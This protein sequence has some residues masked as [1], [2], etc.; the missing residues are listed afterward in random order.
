MKY[1]ARLLGQV[2]QWLGR[3]SFGGL[4]VGTL[5][6][7]LSLL[8]SLLPRPWFFQGVISGISLAI[9]YGIGTALSSIV[10]WLTEYEPPKRFK[11]IAWWVLAVAASVAAVLYF[12]PGRGWQNTVRNLVGEQPLYSRHSFHTSPPALVLPIILINIA[13][14]IRLL[15]RFLQKQLDRILPRR[16]TNVLVGVAIGALLIWIYSGVFVHFFV[17]QAE[18]AYSQHNHATA[19]GV[20]QPKTPLRSG[21]PASFTPWETLG[22]EGRNFV[23]GGPTVHQLEQFSGKPAQEPI[24]V[25]AGY[26]SAKT[27]DARAQ[28][29]VKELI[30][31][32]AF[33]RKVLL[34]ATP[35]GS[36]WLEPQAIDSLEYMWNGDTA[37]VAQQY[38]YLPSWISF[39]VNKSD[40]TNSGRALFDAVYGAWVKLPQNHRPKLY[41]YGLSL[42]S[43]GAQAA[44]S[45]VNGLRNALSGA[46]FVGTPNDTQ[47]WRTVTDERDKNSP[48]WQPVYKDDTAVR[49]A[50]TNHDIMAD[51]SKWQAPRVL[52]VQHGSDPIVWFNF[53]LSFHKPAWLSEPRAPDVSPSVHWY[54]LVTFW[55]ITIDQLSGTKVPAGHGHNYANTATASWAAVTQPPG[56]T[57]ADTTR[58]QKIINTYPIN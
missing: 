22:Y 55:Q 13:R 56:W 20:V 57:S 58:L 47:L 54:P 49:F 31:T 10:R 38:S 28:L 11:H 23:A 21:S 1:G 14:G 37:V 17:T 30:R 8:P 18:H 35:T 43:Y 36:G 41:A 3:F 39:L 16:I 15:G 25:Y 40:A 7:C 5:L 24:R 42:G 46:L 50:A 4:L 34:I 44:Y 27:D 52:Y 19:E 2:N 12:Y 33:N 32:G 26:E 9:G 45:G 6:F 29:A 48:E 51:Q 53:N